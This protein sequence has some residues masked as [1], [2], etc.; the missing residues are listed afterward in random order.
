MR[1]SGVLHQR[2][3]GEPQGTSFTYQGR[4]TDSGAPANGSFDI[5]LRLF[6]ASVA[7]VQVGST[8]TLNDQSV[9]NG[10]FTASLDFGAQFNGSARWLELRVRPGALVGAYTTIL[11]R[12]LLDSTPY[13]QCCVCR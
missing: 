6:D 3:G 4:L 10:V 11:P 12:T 7:G 8:I 2:A 5:E 13:A 1:G 9:A